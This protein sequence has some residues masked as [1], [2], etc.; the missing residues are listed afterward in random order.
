[1]EEEEALEA[2]L[3]FPVSK[4]DEQSGI[5]RADEQVRVVVVVVVVVEVPLC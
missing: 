2:A 3:P 1:L 4:L 5:E